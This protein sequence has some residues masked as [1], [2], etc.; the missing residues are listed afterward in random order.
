MTHHREFPA[1]VLAGAI[2]SLAAALLVF[3]TNLD[4]MFLKGFALRGAYDVHRGVFLSLL[5]LALV[6]SA[7]N[8]A[9]VAPLREQ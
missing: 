7:R 4:R 5:A 2:A 1:E 8:V 6:F 9:R 3:S